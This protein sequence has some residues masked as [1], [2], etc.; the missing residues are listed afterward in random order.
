M[1]QY[2][3]FVLTGEHHF[4]RQSGYSGDTYFVMFKKQMLI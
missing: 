1:G 4:G 2:K 3:L